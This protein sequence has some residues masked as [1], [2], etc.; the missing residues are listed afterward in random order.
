MDKEYIVTLK[1]KDDLEDF[2]AEMSSNG[3]KIAKKRPISRNTHYYMTAKQAEE[4][5][6]DSR[7][8]DVEEV[9]DRMVEIPHAIYNNT[10]YTKNGV[11]S[12][13]NS[14]FTGLSYIQTGSSASGGVPANSI[15]VTLTNHDYA[16]NDKILW[17]KT[18]FSVYYTTVSISSIVDANNFIFAIPGSP[19]NTSASGTCQV[20]KYNNSTDLQW[21]HVHC[22]GTSS[23]RAKGT[24]GRRVDGA[25]DENVNTSVDI[26]NDGKHVD[27][28]IIDRPMAYDLAEWKSPSTNNSRFVQYQW[29][30]ELN[31]IVGS[32]DDD[33]QTLPTGTIT[34]RQG[35]AESGAHG[36]HV[37][38]TVAGQYYGWAREANI[39]NM[40]ITASYASGQIFQGLYVHDYIRAFH[41]NKAVNSTTGRRNPTITNHSYGSATYMQADQGNFE[42][43]DLV[44][45]TWR[46]TTYNSGNPNSSGWTQSGVETDFGITFGLQYYPLYSAAIS[47]DVQDA[48]DD[49]V[50][51]VGAAGNDNLLLAEYNDADWNNSLVYQY[52]ASTQYSIPF[53]RGGAPNTP[54]VPVINVG[55]LNNTRNFTRATSTQYG[56]GITVF[57]PG[58]SIL[59]AYGNTGYDDTKS[60]YGTGNYFGT[61]SGTSM[62][63]PQVCGVLATLATAKRRFSQSDAIGY[64]QR[65]S[66]LNDMTFDTGNGS[67]GD[68]TCQKGSPNKYLIS[69]NPRPTT[70]MIEDVKGERK[71]S[72]MTFPRR[73][74]LNYES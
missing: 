71:T 11:F 21:G 14:Y 7:V 66:V 4:L 53:C 40:A 20:F 56:P 62:A 3:F 29:F 45:V 48:I 46:G 28:I 36:N 41:L 16:V 43:A 44:S 22:A 2:Y 68:D 10:S 1:R 27:V 33:S 74:T 49:G 6:K 65:H 38:S 19:P 13:N 64:L 72:G 47:A 73:A 32:I 34:Y 30:N 67:H 23:Q 18:D 50:V 15:K 58:V 54:D 60:G 55:S 42:F 61:M 26:H 52:D 25:T 8:V 39:Y 51:F 37:G 59:G 35:T 24:F 57:A 5:K 70:G 12:K 9:T 69:K 17:T 31:S 63:S